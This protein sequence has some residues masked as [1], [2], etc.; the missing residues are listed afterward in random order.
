MGQS[1]RESLS[2]HKLNV[3]SVE[4]ESDSLTC[5][6]SLLKLFHCGEEHPELVYVQI[7]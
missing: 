3:G 4:S 6:G 1:Q 5:S 7:S 2:C